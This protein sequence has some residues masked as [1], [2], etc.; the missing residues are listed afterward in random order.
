MTNF[1]LAPPPVVVDGNLAVPI[2]I[3]SITAKLVF[4]GATASGSGDATIEFVVGPQ[5]GN[6][7]LDLRQT[8]T[9]AWLDGAPFP[10][11]QLRHHDFGGGA[12]AD[13]R[14]VES[15]LAA[16][17]MHT[18]RVTYTLGPPQASMA[19]SYLPAMEWSPGPRLAFNFG[20]TDLGAGRYLEAWVPANLVFDQFDL[21]LELQVLDTTV[22]HTVITNGAVTTMA[23]NHWRVAF[24]SRFTALSPLLEVRATDTLAGQ[25]GA[26]TLPASGTAVTVEAWKLAG[27]PIDLA[28]QVAN[29]HGWLAD[30]ELST[31]RYLHGDRFVAFLNV[32]GMEYEGGCTTG[33]GA[34]RHETFHSW[35]ARGVKPASQADGWWD[36]AWTVYNDLGAA[37]SLPF[38]FTDLPVTLAPR[39]PWVR[40]TSP[41]SYTS[42][43]RVFE[44]L[45]AMVGVSALRSA[46]SAFYQANTDRP[47]TT[48]AIEAFLV[49][50]SGQVGIVDAF[51]RFVYG[52]ADPSPAIDLWLRDEVGDIGAGT[53][54]GRFW[55]SPDLWVRNADDG[56]TA[57]QPPKHGQD[58][59]LYATVRNRGVTTA[60]HFLVSFNVKPW[61]GT[62]FL[63]PSDFLPCVAA[64]AGFDLAPGAST[65]VKAR[66]PAA[67]VPP[68]G[69]HACL[70]ASVIARS[71]HPR[72]GLH[73]WE[74]NNL[75]QKNLTVVD[76]RPDAWLVL[77]FVINR[78]S[79][80]RARPFVLELVR[81]KGWQDLEA[82]LLHRSGEG[83]SRVPQ[84][85]VRPATLRARRAQSE[86]ESPPLDCGGGPPPLGTTGHDTVW[87]SEAPD[88]RALRQFE[89][90]EEAA[91]DP[92]PVARLPIVAA[93]GQLYFG[94][95]LRVPRGAQPGDVLRLDV[96]QRDQASQRA[97][98]GLAIEMRVQ[99]PTWHG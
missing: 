48:A 21:S 53:W 65:V 91:F 73:V 97:V 47:V 14:V 8:I 34:L 31:G 37:G 39:N 45:A 26:T 27:S 83:L 17:S 75:A 28:A 5:A 24:P 99:R 92:G 69:T 78:P 10:I 7:I 94:L 13:L 22:G 86:P 1:D 49:S 80:L 23:V 67:Q 61:A 32:G 15:V 93:A 81:P 6:P 88:G 38:D 60:R 76:L 18:L 96:V 19:G 90:G 25:A 4:D 66:W 52:F 64:A 35:W 58:N 54:G 56:G 89:Q 62:E 16:G 29:L 50:W 68:A 12:D 44:G 41:V 70:L 84:S 51:H 42:G 87:T 43:E 55:D 46:M 79:E 20:F 3:K 95:F 71:D 77:P 59:W 40:V 30:N 2:D 63:Y 33:T 57:H 85:M 82:A 98:G 36:E 72:T 74:H 11:G 9:A